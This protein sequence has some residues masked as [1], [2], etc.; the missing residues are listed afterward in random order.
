MA[1]AKSSLA[2]SYNPKAGRELTVSA[3]K[4]LN[5]FP[6]LPGVKWVLCGRALSHSTAAWFIQAS[7]SH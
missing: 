7:E 4:A 3:L 1:W 2:L 6:G 5:R